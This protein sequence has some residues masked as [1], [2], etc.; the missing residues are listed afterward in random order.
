MYRGVADNVYEVGV[1]D[2]DRKLFDELIPL[3]YGTSYNAYLVRGSEKIALIDTVN[4]GRGAELL[5][6]LRALGVKKIDYVIANHAEQDHSGSIPDVLREFPE[7]KVVTNAKCREMLMALLHVP[8]DKFIVVNDRE[9]ISL[10]D[11]TLEF[12]F[13]P[14]VH[15]PETMLTYLVEQQI[16]FPCDF[17]GSHL[18]TSKLF[19]DSPAEIEPHAK[20]YYAEIMMPFRTNIAGHLEVLKKYPIKIIAPSHGPL[21]NKPEIIMELYSKWIGAETENKVLVLYV[22]MHGSTGRAVRHFVE[23]LILQG[24]PV[25]QIDIAHADLGEIAIEL[26]DATTVILATPTVLTGAHPAAVYAAYLFNALR[27]KT[28]YAGLIV[29]YGWGGRCIEQ[30]KGM[31]TNIKAELLEP[32]YIRGLPA[33]KDFELIDKLVLTIA[34]KHRAIFGSEK[35]G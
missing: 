13:A 17:F 18:A 10:G 32:V 28:K 19:V 30:I 14:W 25:R 5:E 6:H 34:E 20:R 15:W 21:Y 29:S 23:Q 33:E 26:V 2:W 8:E 24:I 16:L 27:P 4:S 1:I 9:R 7:A 22:S 35:N 31:L 11:K 12:I 3:P